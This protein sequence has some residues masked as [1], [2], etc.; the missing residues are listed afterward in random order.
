[1]IE[2]AISPTRRIIF[3]SH[4]PAMLTMAAETV[5]YCV[6]VYEWSG[7]YVPV[8]HARHAKELVEEPG[9]YILG[10]TAEC[11]SLFTAP[12]DAL[13]ID[14]DRNFVLTSSPLLPSPPASE[15]SSS[16]GLPSTLNGDVTPPA[17]SAPA[18]RLRWREAR[19]SGPDHCHAWR[20]RVH[21]RSGMV[22]P[23]FD[24][25]CH[26]SRLREDCQVHAP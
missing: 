1:M 2:A 14:L 10:V 24:H 21:P 4:Y 15:T 3:V 6:R 8:V 20:S 23:G 19:P 25:D 18:L 26:G 11:R 17:S 9:P 12:N 22:E 7:L 5:R 13:V 16:P